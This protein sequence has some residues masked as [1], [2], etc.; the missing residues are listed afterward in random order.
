[1]AIPQ[2]IAFLTRTYLEKVFI[3]WIL[4]EVWPGPK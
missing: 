3:I 1:M 4:P 2:V